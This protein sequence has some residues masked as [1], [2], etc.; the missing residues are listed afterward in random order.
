MSIF[1]AFCSYDN[2]TKKKDKGLFFVKEKKKIFLFVKKKDF[3]FCLGKKMPL[4][5]AEKARA[6]LERAL[7]AL[8]RAE[9]R[10]ELFQEQPQRGVVCSQCEHELPA[11][12]IDGGEYR[13]EDCYLD[14][15]VAA[16]ERFEEFDK[17]R[18][19]TNPRCKI[20]APGRPD[21]II[22]IDGRRVLANSSFE[23]RFGV[24][25]GG[26]VRGLDFTEM[27]AKDDTVFKIHIKSED[28]I[29]VFS[30]YHGDS[31]SF[32]V[33]RLGKD[34]PFWNRIIPEFEDI[35]TWED[36]FLTQIE[37]AVTNFVM[38]MSSKV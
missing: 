11:L 36:S 2:R 10:S 37:L 28:E 24:R 1:E 5:A 3:F 18:F 15:N 14:G 20:L 7:R 4:S 30:G 19:N 32:T 26:H 38:F 27:G 17:S 13:C 6:D 21:K 8:K 33:D 9:K 16:A 22:D 25:G 35:L 23:F 31:K 29:Y 34:L 12:V